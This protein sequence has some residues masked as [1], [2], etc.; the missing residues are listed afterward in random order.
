MK[1]PLM[2]VAVLCAVTLAIPALTFA[3]SKGGTVRMLTKKE[4][5]DISGSTPAVQQGKGAGLTRNESGP[6]GGAY[7]SQIA[8]AGL[9]A[10]DDCRACRPNVKDSAFRK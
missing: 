7:L 8:E 3:G 5:Q 9:S 4:M 2:R 6:R 1:V 10:N